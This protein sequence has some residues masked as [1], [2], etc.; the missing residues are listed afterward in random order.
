MTGGLVTA[1]VVSRFDAKLLYA[2][3]PDNPAT[4]TATAALLFVVALAASYF[5]AQ[6]A[7]RIDPMI[8]LRSE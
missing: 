2:I 5:P 8:A 6:R 3:S 4:F 7:T 1:L